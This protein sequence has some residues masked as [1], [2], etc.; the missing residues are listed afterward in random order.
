[1]EQIDFDLFARE[2][3][4][5]V[6]VNVAKIVGLVNGRDDPLAFA[7]ASLTTPADPAL[8]GS[9][10]FP[11][12]TRVSLSSPLKKGEAASLQFEYTITPVDSKRKDLPYRI[13][14]E[15]SPGLKEICLITDFSWLPWITWTDYEKVQML[16]KSNFFTKM[17]RPAWRMVVRHPSSYQT[18][19]VDGRLEKTIDSGND[20]V[21]TWACRTGG[22]PQLLIGR[23]DKIVVKDGSVSVVFL[24]AKGRYEPS[25]VE[26]MGRF[27]IRAFRFYSQLFG[28]LSGN[29]MHIAVSSAGMGGHGAF[30]GT[31]LD[32]Q[33]FQKKNQGSPPEG[34]FDETAAHELAHSW[35][36]IS[37]SSYGRGTKFLREAFCNFAT[38]LFAKDVYQQDLFQDNLAYLFFRGTAKNR[39]FEDASDNANLAYTKGALVLDILRQEM[40][41]ETF[42]RILKLFAAKYKDAY[43]TFTD[44]V[45]LCNEITMR[46][47]MP[48]FIRW[49]YGEGYPVYHLQ[50]FESKPDHGQW[51]TAV[52]IRNDGKGIIL[53]P[54]ALVQGEHVREETFFVPEGEEKMM[55]YETPDRVDQVMIDPRHRVFQGDQQEARLK[56]LGIKETSWAWMNYFMGVLYEERGERGKALEL[57]SK[58]IAGHEEFL[59]P[60][61]ASPA[62]YFSRGILL[63]RMGEGDKAENDLKFFLD[64]IL[65]TQKRPKDLAAAMRSLTYAVLVSGTD[66]EK[67]AQLLQFLTAVTGQKISLDSELSDW[68]TWWEANRSVFKLPQSAYSLSP[69]GFG[70]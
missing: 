67:Q 2:R 37:I 28:E 35:F 20:T 39:L 5:G 56:M 48:F 61:M 24:V 9:D 43:V 47:W 59:G 49:C 12:I 42:F 21:S 38:W 45:S 65:G 58:A 18:L 63:L 15:F 51:K 30:L 22:M 44:F 57:I 33:S 70:K 26:S 34:T 6:K 3:Y 36:G 40:G 62:L 41:N 8:E 17:P 64:G 19:V 69:K 50:K 11:K 32:I 27:L 46:D 25:A 7:R 53:C 55:T 16:D 14:D 31:F 54:L 23:S 60:R 1:M 10:E 68:R 66:Q 13:I 29:E 4:Y 52:I